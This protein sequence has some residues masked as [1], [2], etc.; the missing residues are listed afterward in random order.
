MHNTYTVDCNFPFNLSLLLV[1]FFSSKS[2]RGY[3][4]VSRAV[5]TSWI[6]VDS[7][8][9]RF[10]II[11]L[12]GVRVATFGPICNQSRNGSYRK[13]IE[14][15]GIVLPP[16]PKPAANYVPAQLS[17]N[18]LFLSGHLPTREDGSLFTGRIENDSQSIEHGYAA[19]RQAGLNIIA[20]LKQ[21]LGDLDRV[22][23]VV[24][25]LGLVQSTDNF[26]EQHKVM[27]GCSDVLVEIFGSRG[28]HARSAVGTNSLPLNISVE[29][30][31]I[32]R[33]KDDTII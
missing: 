26:H 30:E 24:K 10:G 4:Y 22:E 18:L 16:A 11:V 29:V 13:R 28:I 1:W 17:G 33:V 2:R 3:S 9:D 32:V 8:H 7:R 6:E 31:A 20:T 12:V 5:P 15:L 14:E 23:Q 19:A 21:E 27:N 25:L